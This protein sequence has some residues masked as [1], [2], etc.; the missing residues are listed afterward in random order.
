MKC[1]FE[2]CCQTEVPTDSTPIAS[3]NAAKSVTNSN[4]QRKKG[5]RKSAGPSFV[6]LAE[7]PV[8]G[9]AETS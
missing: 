4:V 9:L 3:W 1:F 2:L 7:V 5:L 8:G 6:K